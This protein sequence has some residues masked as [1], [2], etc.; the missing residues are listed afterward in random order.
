[1]RIYKELPILMR[2]GVILYGNLYCPDPSGV[3]PT[4]VCRLPYDK[5]QERHSTDVLRP[6]P[7]VEAGY[8]V[9]LQDQRGTGTSDG[10]LTATGKNEFQDGYDTIEWVATQPWSNQKVAMIG[11]S[12]H[13]FAQLAAASMHPPHLVTIAPWEC[14]SW[15]PFNIND[16]GTITIVN[17]LNWVYAQSKRQLENMKL[18]PEERKRI[19]SELDLYQDRLPEQLRFRPLYRTPAANVR[20]FPLV[21]EYVEM[22]L[23][24]GDFH[25]WKSIGRPVDFSTLN[26]PMFHLSGWC[27]FLKDATID[28]Y[29]AARE[30][31]GTEFMRENQV[32]IMGPWNHGS[33]MASSVGEFFFGEENSGAGQSLTKRLI[34]WLDHFIMNK[35]LEPFWQMP[36]HY[37]VMQK[38]EWRSAGRWPEPESEEIRL[39]LDSNGY[40][41]TLFGNGRMSISFGSGNCDSYIHDPMDPVP[42]KPADFDL[43]RLEDLPEIMDYT[44]IEK[45]EDVLVYT[46]EVL[47]E[48]ITIVGPVLVKLYASTTAEDVDFMCRLLDVFPD[49]RP[50]NVTDGAVRAR[51][52][53]SIHPQAVREHQT[54]T[55]DRIVP[56]E[57][58]EYD[59]FAGNTAWYFAAGHRVRLEVASSGF[60]RHDVNPG[61]ACPIGTAETVRKSVQCIY[62]EERYPSSVCL[63]VVEDGPFRSFP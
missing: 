48:G 55:E 21:H 22:V 53:H 42:A 8:C 15:A 24:V 37:F 1:M 29:M 31:G 27:D 45:R 33:K 46:S 9:L 4:I 62:H 10:L 47:E 60:P 41:N 54:I 16:G 49:G 14:Q 58:T 39:Y 17:K 23:N 25:Y 26:L 52:R 2:D 32:L 63:S 34:Q 59:I 5:N 40:A 57:I 43:K 3:Y 56:G 20:N 61:M 12:N 44:E 6:E 19:Q 50:F 35:K 7:F 13:G 51:F 30:Y 38:N 28:N 18:M 36:V 11:M